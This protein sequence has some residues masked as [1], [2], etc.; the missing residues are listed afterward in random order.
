VNNTTRAFSLSGASI[1]GNGI[2]TKSGTGTV[3][4]N[5]A[6]TFTGGTVLDAGNI[7]LGNSTA[8]AS[9]LGSGAVTMN[10]GVLKMF[11][12]GNATHAGTLP[13]TLNVAGSARLEVAPRCGFSGEVTGSGTL[14]YR[15]NYVRADVTGDWSAFGGQLNVTT[16]GSGDFRIAASYSWPGL[17]NASVNLATGTYFYMSGTVNSGAGT[18]IPIG[19]L[20]G[21]AGSHVRGGPTSGRTLT[22]RIGGKGTAATYSGDIVEQ[23][24][25]TTTNLVKT[26]TGLW[27]IAGPAT[28][29]GNTT[30]EAGTLCILTGGS[31][32]NN[33]SLDVQSGATFCVNGGSVSV[34]TVT[35]SSG[36]VFSSIGGNITG[37]FNNGGTATITSGTLSVTGDV[38]NTGTLRVT[39][40]GRLTT[41]GTFS[42]SGILDLLTSASDLPANFVNTGIVIENTERR[43]LTSSKSGANF[44]V[45]VTGHVGHTYQLQRTDTLGGAWTNIGA[46]IAGNG[47]TLT[48]TDTG[49]AVGNAGFYRVFVSP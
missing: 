26:G 35:I 2:F 15:T 31:I 48:L 18:T 25:G 41:T 28:H 43:I 7:Q 33:A 45:T 22:Y 19:A 12:A 46:P 16:A 38:T 20:S 49:G 8:N 39:G 3:T 17:P 5:A 6:N 42:N 21:A 47:T 29:R 14:D 30:V 32:T 23:N 34:E 1:T 40:G 10:G 4:L 24:T 27:N 11:S 44:S 36:A 9:A 37:E 13:N